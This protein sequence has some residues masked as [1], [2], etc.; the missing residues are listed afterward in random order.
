MTTPCTALHAFGLVAMQS[1]WQLRLDFFVRPQTG[2]HL[3]RGVRPICH[4][5]TPAPQNHNACF[6]HRQPQTTQ[7]PTQFPYLVLSQAT[8]M[9]DRAL[10]QIWVLAKC[11]WDILVTEA[12]TREQSS[13]FEILLPR[14]CLEHEFLWPLR[15]FHCGL[16]RKRATRNGLHWWTG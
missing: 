1:D 6:V 5:G 11:C 4:G 9:T 10:H 16:Y 7:F 14:P 3:I 12:V 2:Q 13:R 15:I 8:P